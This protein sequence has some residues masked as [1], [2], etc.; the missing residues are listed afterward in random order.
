MTTTHTYISRI[1]PTFDDELIELLSDKATLKEVSKDTVII[2]PGEYLKYTVL[3]AAG[4]IKVYRESEE[5]NE[6]FLYFLNPGNACALSMLCIAHHR[7][8]EMLAVAE[9]DS[10]LLLIPVQYTDEL[11]KYAAWNKFVIETYRARFEEL[12]EVFDNLAFR[13]M[14]ER[15][16]FY[17]K[18]LTKNS[19]SNSIEITH[20]QIANDLSTSREV[21][22]RLLKKLEQQGMLRLNRKYIE[23]LK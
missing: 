22:S 1:F 15:L 9:E 2:N 5:G 11:S 17:L 4:S 13:G 23:W 3:L 21:I 20:Q 16:E 8:S 14:D 6:A 7:K 18:R 19:R 12:L 10:I